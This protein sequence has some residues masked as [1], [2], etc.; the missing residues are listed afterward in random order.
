MVLMAIV[1]AVTIYTTMMSTLQSVMSLDFLEGTGKIIVI[2]FMIIGSMIGVLFSWLLYTVIFYIISIIFSGE[3]DFKRL[4]EFTSYGFIPNIA[5]SLISAYYTNK[6][7]SNIDF[8][9]VADPQAV[10]DMIFADPSMKIASIL[11]IIFTLWSANIWIF[12]VKYARDL[13]LRNA[14]ITVGI[15]IGLGLLYT[16]LTVFVLR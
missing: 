8:A 13:S 12:G 10:Q 9:S 7:F 14:V 1:G 2:I 15:P 16:I 3:G 6:V 5:S 4:M 11:G